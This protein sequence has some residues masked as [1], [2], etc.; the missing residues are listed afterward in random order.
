MMKRIFIYCLTVI[1][2]CTFVSCSDDEQFTTSRT[3]V[4]SLPDDTLKMD[5]IFSGVPSSTYTFWIRNKNSHALRVSDVRLGDGTKGFRVNV[6]GEYLNP[7]ISGLEVLGKDSVLV[8]VELTPRA[9]S[10]LE[11]QPIDEQLVLTLESGVEQRIQLRAWAWDAERWTDKTVTSDEEVSTDKPI[12]VYGKLTVAEGAKLTVKGSTLYFHED[13]MLEV[14]G[15]L[16]A[17]NVTMRGDRLD[18]MFSYLPYDN[19]SGQWQ[20]IRV[21]ENAHVSMTDCNVHGTYLG[22]TVAEGAVVQ[23]TRTVIH[24]N[25]GA[26]IYATGAELT[27]DHCL[28]SNCEGSLLSTLN[29]HVTLTYCTLAQYYP[30]AMRDTALL[31]GEGTTHNIE[32]MLIAGYE[33]ELISLEEGVEEIPEEAYHIAEKEDFVLIDE[34]NLIYDFHLKPDTESAGYGFDY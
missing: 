21:M 10:E 30:F 6:D 14:A 11:P 13:V 26:G 12:L 22:M 27:L 8:F 32:K 24:N 7:S 18:D 1:V 5:T 34:E 25:A 20:G 9:T 17:E 15:T 29:S 4:L 23:L 33:E 2:V 16:E 31:L 19:V 28:L 3:D